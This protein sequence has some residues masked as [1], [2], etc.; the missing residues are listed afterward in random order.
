MTTNER[1]QEFDKIVSV[2]EATKVWLMEHNFFT[3][4][5]SRKYHGAYEGG[6]FD[7]SLRV[8]QHLIKLTENNNLQWQRPE[9]PALVGIFHDLCKIDQYICTGI[10]DLE[11]RKQY[12]WNDHQLLKGHGDKSIILL[13]QLT[14]L[15]EEE[16]LCIRYHMGAFVEQE[17]W[18]DYTGAVEK[19]PNVLW[20]HHADMLASHVDSV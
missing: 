16:I 15:T 5:A 12:K 2:P 18:N 14:T 13:S 10:E 9:S 8:A 11:G 17:E 4:P 6:L 7:H 19:Y 3:A 1:I 20:T